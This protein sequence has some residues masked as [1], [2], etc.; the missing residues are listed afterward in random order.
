LEGN[1]V[2]LIFDEFWD[3]KGD[4]YG[5]AHCDTNT[6]ITG[7]IGLHN[8]VLFVLPHSGTVTAASATAKLQSSFHNIDLVL[9]VGIC[10]GVPQIEGRNAY[11]GDTVVS[12][13]IIPYDY[14][15]Y[16]GS[17]ENFRTVNDSLSHAD[18][19]IRS[20]LRNFELNLSKRRL[21]AEAAEYLDQLQQDA[22]T[23]QPEASYVYPRDAP[24]QLFAPHFI[25]KHRKACSI[26]ESSPDNVCK[27]AK[28]MSCDELQCHQ[29]DNVQ[30]TRDTPATYKPSIFMGRIGSG[31]TLMKSGED[32]DRIAYKHNLIAF[33][34]EGTGAWDVLPCIIIK[35]ISDYADSHKNNAWHEFAA[36]TA[37]SVT[38]AILQR[39]PVRDSARTPLQPEGKKAHP[40]N[41]D[42]PTNCIRRWALPQKHLHQLRKQCQDKPR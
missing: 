20:M 5:R 29:Q 17:S 19:D 35:S 21:V 4:P 2:T 23:Q 6:Y 42:V 10:G 3:E 32:R 26:C 16:Y 13:A 39:R 37:A 24:D 34:M 14:D 9:V 18:K 1:A 40:L 7:R 28:T 27:I 38:K 11:L 30:R 41:L 36:A 15:K 25:H 22:T 31:N 12:T 8:V 33:E